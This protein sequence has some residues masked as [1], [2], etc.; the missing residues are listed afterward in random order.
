MFHRWASATR[1][2]AALVYQTLNESDW[3]PFTYDYVN[4]HSESGGFCKKGSNNFTV[5]KHWRPIL[6]SVYASHAGSTV[7]AH[8]T[9]PTEA[10]SRYGGAFTEAYLNVTSVKAGQLSLELTLIGKTPTMIGESTMLSFAP[11][12]QLKTSGAWSISKLGH[13]VDPEEVINGGNQ[14]NHGAWDGG[15]TVTTASGEQLQLVSLDASNMCPQTADFPWGNPL[16][17]GSDGLLQ[18][19]KGSVFGMGVNLH[20]SKDVCMH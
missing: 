7:L 16:P 12:P 9:M 17:A 4:G 19:K 11:A 15:S 1:P 14:F 10:S 8:M 18:L 5:S 2:L 20:N 6:N 13:G 3:L